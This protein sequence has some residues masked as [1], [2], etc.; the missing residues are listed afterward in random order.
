VRA[1]VTYDVWVT[2]SEDPTPRL[3]DTVDG[4]PNELDVTVREI[5]AVI[6]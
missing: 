4:P 2:T 5:Q 1:T 6:R 3:A